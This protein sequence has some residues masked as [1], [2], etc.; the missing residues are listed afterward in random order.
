MAEIRFQIPDEIIN[1]LRDK[2]RLS[3]NT[4]VV[5]EA[6]TLLNWAAG[7]RENEQVHLF[8]DARRQGHRPPDDDQP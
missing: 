6:L 7:E 3:N 4:D 1:P 8:I 2:L 5:R